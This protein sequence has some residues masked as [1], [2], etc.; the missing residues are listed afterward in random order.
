MDESEV[1]Y[2]ELTVKLTGTDGNV[3]SVISAVTG[4][5]R[6][7]HGTAASAEFANM[8]FDC[9]SYDEVLRLAMQSVNIE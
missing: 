8:A 6:R 5:I 2:P 4:A 9:N 7:S 3:F 1:R